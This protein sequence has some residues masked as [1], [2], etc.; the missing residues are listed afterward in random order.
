MVIVWCV[1]LQEL[2]YCQSVVLSVVDEVG[3]RV[4]MDELL[5]TTS[6]DN[7]GLRCAAVTILHSYCELTKADYTEYVPQLFRGLLHLF[8]DTDERVLN[9]AWDCLNAVIKVCSC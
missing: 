4:V 1:V 2:E 3:V 7:P 6:K 8:T 9:A 5:A